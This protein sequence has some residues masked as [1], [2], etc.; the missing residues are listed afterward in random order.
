MGAICAAREVII[1]VTGEEKRPM[2]QR[3]LTGDEVMPIVKVLRHPVKKLL[4][5]DRSAAEE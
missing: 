5:L 2:V 3:M 4:F 1:I